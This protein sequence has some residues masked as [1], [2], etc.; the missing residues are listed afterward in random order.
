[1]M[2]DALQMSNL[3]SRFYACLDARDYDGVIACC[4]DDAV[5]HR[6]GQPVTG[7]A[8]IRK[9]LASRPLDFHTGHIVTNVIVEQAS[10][11]EGRVMFYMAGHPYNGE[12]PDGQYVPLPHAHI[13]AAYCDTMR[14]VGNRWF[15]SEKK[16]VRTLYQDAQK[17][18]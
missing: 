14:K 12:V 10:D 6:R 13:L 18:R 9:A 8:A 17:L 5:W 7:H 1:M 11:T 2:H 3:T 16:L 4:A 15:I